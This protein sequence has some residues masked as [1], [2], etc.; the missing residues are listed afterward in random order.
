MHYILVETQDLL[1][2]YLLSFAICGRLLYIYNNIAKIIALQLLQ[3]EQVSFLFRMVHVVA[4]RS[5][6]YV[7]PTFTFYG[8][9]FSTLDF[10]YRAWIFSSP[11]NRS[12]NPLPRQNLS[13]LS[14]SYFFLLS[15]LISWVTYLASFWYPRDISEM[16]LL[17][18]GGF[19]HIL[20]INP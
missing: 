10:S 13:H 8:I 17:Y 19:T 7:D 6:P 20:R 12:L 4:A 18:P 3:R 9:L 1:S 15:S 5:P 11:I 14:F 2:F 16:F